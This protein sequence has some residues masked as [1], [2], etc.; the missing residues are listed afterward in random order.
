MVLFSLTL[1]IILSVLGRRRKC[2]INYFFKAILWFAYLGAD[3][4]AI[5]TLGKLSGSHAETTAAN[6]FRAYWAPLLLVHLGGPDTITAYA[7]EDNKLWIRHLVI[8]IVKVIL[9]I[10]VVCLSWTFSWLSFF[11]LPLILAGII[12]YVEKILC[13]KLNDSQKTKPIFSNIFNLRGHPDPNENQTLD[14]L[15]EAKGTILSAYL[16]F[17]IMRLDVNDY[18]SSENLRDIGTR[19]KAYLKETI[20]MDGEKALEFAGKYFP[21]SYGMDILVEIYSIQLGFMFDVV[22]TKASLI[23]TKLG[24]FLRLTSF[25]S[26]FSI[27]M[28]FFINII[29]EPKFYGSRIDIAITG[30]LLSGAIAQELYAAWLM[31]SSDWAVLVGEFH[32]N[33]LVR[34]MFKVSL[35]YFPCLL[36]RSKRWSKHMGQFDLL[37]YCW[38]YKKREANQSHGS[39]P[40]ISIGSEIVEMWHKYRFTKFG[41]VPHFLQQEGTY[42]E[43]MGEYFLDRSLKTTRGGQALQKYQKSD[44]LKWSI[45]LE[46]DHSIIIWHLATSVCYLQEDNHDDEAMKISKHVSDYMMY[47]LAMCPALLLSEHS[48]SFW[49]DHACDNLKQLVS[50]AID[51]RNAAS[52]L[53]S[54]PDI[55]VHESREGTSENLKREVRKLVKF[56]KRPDNKWEMIRDVWIEILLYAAVS[57]QHINHVKQL[58]EGIELLSLIWLSACS[59]MMTSILSSGEV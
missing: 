43:F 59:S 17:T 20:G 49:L 18:L 38:H 25:T 58:G 26:S 45:E 16:L 37:E 2:K 41:L 28:L 56:L 51:I 52:R 29:N 19:I 50:P 8:L 33:V 14:P 22:Y 10:Y 13:L 21:R 42:Y 57:S 27:L 6:V 44:Q 36:H 7:F 46:F 53:L 9:V 23:Y 24:C 32:H 5:A 3:W 31:L 30:I 35:K 4:I 34:K 12:K 1:Q 55:N 39:L 11:S 54:R 48:K 15:R 40:K 47:L